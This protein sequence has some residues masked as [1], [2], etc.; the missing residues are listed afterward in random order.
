MHT[1][2]AC[3]VPGLGYSDGMSSAG[4]LHDT[5][6]P[7]HRGKLS[8]TVPVCVGIHTVP[9][10]VQYCRPTKAEFHSRRLVG[11]EGTLKIPPLLWAGCPAAQAA[12]GWARPRMG[13][14][15]CW[16]LTALL[17]KDV[18]LLCKLN[19][20]SCSLKPFLRCPS[21]TCSYKKSLSLL[22]MSSSQV[23]EG[24]NEASLGP[25][26]LQAD[27]PLPQPLHSE[28]LQ[29]QNSLLWPHSH[30]PTSLC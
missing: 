29:P 18:F 27:F 23:L 28:V 19:L 3:R 8:C 7:A 10:S 15:Q 30:N 26:L 1:H 21:T 16:G 24:C 22:F 17:V 6:V 9:E 13:Y 4:S 14:P 25:C 12:Q 5:W 11:L 2:T 20:P